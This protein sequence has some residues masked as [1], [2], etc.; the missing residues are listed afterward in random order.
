MKHTILIGTFFTVMCLM[1][2][3]CSTCKRSS[4]IIAP[5]RCVVVSGAEVIYEVHLDGKLV[6][7]AKT[8]PPGKGEM[9][10]E[11]V[12]TP[13]DH[14]LTVTAPGYETWGETITVL[15]GVKY[16][17]LFLVELNKRK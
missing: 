9:S 4:Q 15:D 8:L 10:I 12:A 17:Q 3:S 6:S 7:S 13:G 2:T 16:G 1:M 11:L 5:F 14:V